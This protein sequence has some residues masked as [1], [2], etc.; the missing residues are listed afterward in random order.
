MTKMTNNIYFRKKMFFLPPASLYKILKIMLF[1]GIKYKKKS[2]I[3]HDYTKKGIGGG[4][5]AAPI[6]IYNIY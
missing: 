2:N 6:T 1:K 4:L 3:N 5:V